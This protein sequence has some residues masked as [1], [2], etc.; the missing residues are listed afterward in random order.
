MNLYDLTK[1]MGYAYLD[2]CT[3]AG[4]P[5]KGNKEIALCRLILEYGIRKGKIESNPFDGL[6]KKYDH[7][8]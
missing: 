8:K 6:C 5:E 4:R 2:A 1:S 7:Q 3:A